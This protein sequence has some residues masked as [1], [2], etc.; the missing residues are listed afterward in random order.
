[1]KVV[2]R[3]IFKTNKQGGEFIADKKS[4]KK[5]KLKNFIFQKF[6]KIYAFGSPK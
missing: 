4:L 6:P 2:W 3:Y 1:V 5:N